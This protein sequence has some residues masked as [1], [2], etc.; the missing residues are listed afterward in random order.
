MIAGYKKNLGN[1]TQVVVMGLDS[2]SDGCMAITYYSELT[3]S[4][5]LKQL[6]NWHEGCSWLQR[7]DKDTTFV[8]APAPSDIA[9]TAFAVGADGKMQAKL[10]KTT[11]K[12]LLPCIVDGAPLPFDLV[13]S[14]V[15][16]ASCRRGNR[17]G[18]SESEQEYWR[19]EKNIGIA[20]S[21]FR[22]FH[23][24]RSYQMALERER[25]SRDYLYGRLLA[26]AERLEEKALYVGKEKRETNAGKLMQ[27][28]TDHPY[29]TWLTIETSL[30]PYKVR[31]ITK[32][33][34]FL[35]VLEQ[36]LDGVFNS[37]IH[38][39]FTSNNR[40]TGEFLLGYHCQRSALPLKKED[41]EKIDSEDKDAVE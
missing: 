9:E 31:L 5:F 35:W 25:K 18:N 17:Y 30:T 3:G 6:H 10:R 33:P 24:E 8:G 13:E 22:Y 21:L 26:L 40:L 1:T 29:S 32:R 19:W 2:A 28:F 15:R 16:R 39:D 34:Y 37:F 38:D 7:F 4:D 41:Q 20:C 23:K 27:R 36:E 12:R 11:V 14:C